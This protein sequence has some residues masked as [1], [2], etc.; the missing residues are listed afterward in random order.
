MPSHRLSNLPYE[1]DSCLNKVLSTSYI[2]TMTVLL[3][4]MLVAAAVM[5]GIACLPTKT[6]AVLC[7]LD[8]SQASDHPDFGVGFDLTASYG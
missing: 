4:G 6:Q 1:A 2:Y 7:I 8:R 3:Y 5:N